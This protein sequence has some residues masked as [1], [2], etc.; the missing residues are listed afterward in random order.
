[1]KMD[2]V[3]LWALPDD[4]VQFELVAPDVADT[5]DTDMGADS[6]G[7]AWTRTLSLP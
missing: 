1:M 3:L 2:A 4:W 6:Q 7:R 5:F